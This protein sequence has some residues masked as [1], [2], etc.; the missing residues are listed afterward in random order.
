MAIDKHEKVDAGSIGKD[1][2]C[3]LGKF[4]HGAG[5][6]QLGA[7]PSYALCVAKHAEFHREAGRVAQVINDGKYAEAD[8]L[9]DGKTYAAASFAVVT[10][11]GTMKREGKL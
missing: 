9:L 3:D 11:I 7:L 5:K 10:A 6:A 2:C 8:K 1:N 4:L